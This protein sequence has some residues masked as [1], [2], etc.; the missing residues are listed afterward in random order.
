MAPRKIAPTIENLFADDGQLNDIPERQQL[1]LL[2]KQ[3]EKLR[4]ERKDKKQ[5]TITLTTIEDKEEEIE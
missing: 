1:N 3:R 2:R 4:Y 5:K